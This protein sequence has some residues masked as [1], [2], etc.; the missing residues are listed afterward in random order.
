MHGLSCR[1][2]ADRAAVQKA[3]AGVRPVSYGVQILITYR[4]P[5][6]HSCAVVL[7]DSKRDHRCLVL[8]RKF[9]ISGVQRPLAV[10]PLVLYQDLLS[11]REPFCTTAPLAPRRFPYPAVDVDSFDMSCFTV[12]GLC[13]SH[14][15]APVTV[16][17]MGYRPAADRMQH[18][19]S[20]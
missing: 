10:R 8:Y 15:A 14:I 17:C 2:D 9:E 13:W 20:S 16:C 6:R 7:A 19:I 11:T 5:T 3:P 12:T 18:F 1:I 4:N